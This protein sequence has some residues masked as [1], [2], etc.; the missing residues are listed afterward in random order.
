LND[1]HGRARDA[2]SSGLRRAAKRAG[3]EGFR[4]H[5]CRH[6]F[7]SALAMSGVPTRGLQ[8]LLGHADPRM[9]ARYAHLSGAYPG[10]RST[11]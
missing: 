1:V 11:R 3:L 4:L 9:T 8:E 2:I 10:P 7:A 5:D 6:G